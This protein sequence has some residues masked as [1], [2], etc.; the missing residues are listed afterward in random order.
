MLTVLACKAA[1]IAGNARNPESILKGLGA[2]I[3]LVR[4]DPKSYLEIMLA[5][6][7]VEGITEREDICSALE[8]RV[9]AIAKGP[10]SA[11]IA[12][13]MTAR[14]YRPLPCKWCC[15]RGS[16]GSR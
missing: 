15:R 6:N 11:N 10:V 12:T 7:Q 13:R 8:R 4:A 2:C 14:S 9:A 1:K 3:H 5:A 16:P